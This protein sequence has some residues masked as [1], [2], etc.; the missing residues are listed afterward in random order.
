MNGATHRAKSRI[1]IDAAQRS[2]GSQ[3]APASDDEQGGTPLI[4]APKHLQ[5]PAD[6]ETH[7]QYWCEAL[8]GELPV[9]E[10]V[11][12]YARPGV[13]TTNGGVMRARVES[14]VS[15]VLQGSAGTVR[16]VWSDNDAGR[17]D[18]MGSGA[19]EACRAGRGCGGIP[20]C[21]P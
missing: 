9:L 20:V 12:D 3:P 5:L 14:E 15:A 19:R 10:M 17:A 7:M 18:S 13:L 4:T 11:T 21:K 6:A 8:R 1:L 16:C 2:R